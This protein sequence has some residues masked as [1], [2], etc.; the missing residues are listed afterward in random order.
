[1]WSGH[2]VCSSHCIIFFHSCFHSLSLC[3]SLTPSL[4]L[5]HSPSFHLSLAHSY[6]PFTLCLVHSFSFSPSLFVPCSFS[7]YL[8]SSPCLLDGLGLA[9]GQVTLGL[10]QTVAGRFSLLCQLTGQHATSLT[11]NLRRRRDLSSLLILDHAPVFLDSYLQSVHQMLTSCSICF[12]TT[13]VLPPVDPK[14]QQT[15][16]SSAFI[17]HWLLQQWITLANQKESFPA[18]V[19]VFF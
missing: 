5:P 13:E 7:L 8:P 16:A 15:W 2:Y 4:C 18:F 17:K 10:F 9:L 1:M 12:H 11:A 6:P 3:L 14:W 19:I